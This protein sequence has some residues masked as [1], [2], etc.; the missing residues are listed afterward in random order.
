MV[1]GFC[2]KWG[3]R[4][5]SGEPGLP[6]AFG[7]YKRPVLGLGNNLG[8]ALVDEPAYALSTPEPGLATTSQSHKASFFRL[9]M[10]LHPQS[11]AVKTK[12]VLK[13]YRSNVV[14]TQTHPCME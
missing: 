2:T 11:T 9:V 8:K 6:R 4:G 12:T 1:R 3:P 13:N 7:V 14:D 5:R 10:L